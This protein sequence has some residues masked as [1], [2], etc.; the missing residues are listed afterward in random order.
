[1][2]FLQ[3]CGVGGGQEPQEQRYY[4]VKDGQVLANMTYT[5]WTMFAESIQNLVAPTYSN[6]IVYM[7][8]TQ[9][10]CSCVLGTTSAIN[11]TQ[12]NSIVVRAKAPATPYGLA[13]L[14]LSPGTTNIGSNTEPHVFITGDVFDEFELDLSEINTSKYIEV[15][16]YDDR[17]IQMT[18]LYLTY[19][20]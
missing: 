1:M 9:G 3:A 7:T 6:N 16:C 13:G 15:L 4:L 19:Y 10:K 20:M 5:G 11:L 18:D 17:D 8:T 14:Y 2:A 12:Y